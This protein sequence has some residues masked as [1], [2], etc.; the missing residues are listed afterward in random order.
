[1]TQEAQQTGPI[2]EGE[3]LYEVARSFRRV[4][5]S[6]EDPSQMVEAG[7]EPAI[8]RIRSKARFKHLGRVLDQ[9]IVELRAISRDIAVKAVRITNVDEITSVC[10]ELCP[11]IHDLLKDKGFE[12]R[13]DITGFI[14]AERERLRQWVVGKLQMVEEKNPSIAMLMQRLSGVAEGEV[15]DV[16]SKRL[17]SVVG[18]C[19]ED[20]VVFLSPRTRMEAGPAAHA[21]SVAFERMMTSVRS[22]IA[23]LTDVTRDEIIN[24]FA[25]A[26]TEFQSS[27]DASLRSDDRQII[28]SFLS[29]CLDQW[30]SI[31]SNLDFLAHIESTASVSEDFGEAKIRTSLISH[32]RFEPTTAQLADV[33]RLLRKLKPPAINREKGKLKSSAVRSGVL[34]SLA[35]LPSC[36]ELGLPALGQ[37]LEAGLRQV[38]ESQEASSA[39][40]ALP[41]ESSAP[42]ESQESKLARQKQYLWS[43]VLARKLIPEQLFQDAELDVLHSGLGIWRS[44]NGLRDKD[45]QQKW[46]KLDTKRFLVESGILDDLIAR[47]SGTEMQETSESQEDLRLSASELW[48]EFRAFVRS[49]VGE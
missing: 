42:I 15:R 47:L 13:K 3:L 45:A 2:Q 35:A 11:R 43:L 32:E 44:R 46:T 36:A 34:D 9:L 38:R 16:L 23:V 28:S 17:S 37:V 49:V 40:D 25:N 4:E 7:I 31:E 14:D 20:A 1:M 18:A 6:A 48:P 27:P 21:L 30:K 41:D 29:E 10:E 22:G 5:P 39:A 24:V 26:I 12:Q 8:G 33:E 19:C